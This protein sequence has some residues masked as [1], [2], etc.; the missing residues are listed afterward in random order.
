MKAVVL[1]RRAAARRIDDDRVEA[2]ALDLARPGVDVGARLASA[3]FSAPMW[4]AS[5]AAA[6][7]VLGDHDLDARR[8]QEPDRR[9]VDLGRQHALRASGKQRHAARRSRLRARRAH[10]GRLA[11]RQRRKGPGRERQ[12]RVA[13]A[14]PD[15]QAP[16]DRAKHAS[17]RGQAQRGRGTAPG[18]GKRRTRSRAQRRVEERAAVGASNLDTRSDRRDGR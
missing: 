13:A 6:T 16:D 8:V 18:A 1:D 2:L 7:L 3:R 11:D 17:D 9:G 10:A 12:H 5:D 14:A 4:W 15:R